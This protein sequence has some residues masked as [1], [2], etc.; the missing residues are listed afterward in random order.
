MSNEFITTQTDVIFEQIITSLEA[1]VS[2]PLY[3]GDERRIFG[4]ALVPLFAAMYN[5]MNDACRQ[6][7]LRYARGEVLEAL[8][9]RA[10]VERI[11]PTEA[12]TT[13]RFTL[14]EP[15]ADNVIIPE[16]TR[17]TSDSTRYFATTRA[18]VI[19]A[20]ELTVD[21]EAAS[22][23][24][25]TKYND[26][27]I[28]AINCIVDPVVFVD[29]V[30]NTKVTIGGGDE[31]DDDSLRERIRV[32]PSK[33]ST[34]GPVNG[35]KYWAMSADSTIADVQVK[36]EE[37]RI[38]RTLDVIDSKAFKGG[39]NL[40]PDSLKVYTNGGDELEAGT[41]YDAEYDDALLTIT[42]TD[43]GAMSSL[44]QIKIEITETC[45]GVVRIIPICEDGQIPDDTILAKVE[46]ACGA[47]E[48]R[49]LTDHV[50]VERPAVE[51]YDIVLKYYTTTAEESQCI[52]TVEGEGGAIDQFNKWQSS[53]LGR[54]INPDKLRA[55][56]LAP[57]G[58]GTVGASRVVITS[59]TFTELNDTTIAKF[60]GN[61]TITHEVST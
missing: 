48:V 56:I 44:G 36:S 8:G 55:L 50:I 13:L 6:K 22:V 43:G 29:A 4:E 42:A 40:L 11:P 52:Q 9:E 20:G 3:P 32:A 28:G 26:I 57:T 19:T 14:H 25:G 37:R 15:V 30:S 10:G 39:D 2:E 58:E 47:S 59:P 45:A 54:D 5:A 27:P 41:D 16:G 1:S 12:T 33:L 23:E 61:K 21:V 34:A 24:G 38:E 18:A 60:S 53:Q 35:Y 7:M 31:E 49:P 17:A 46:A 51:Y